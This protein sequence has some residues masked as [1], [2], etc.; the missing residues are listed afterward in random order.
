[1]KQTKT[2]RCVAELNVAWLVQRP[3]IYLYDEKIRSMI[4][5][6]VAMTGRSSRR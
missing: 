5:A 2:R 3:S 4:S 1:M 6:P